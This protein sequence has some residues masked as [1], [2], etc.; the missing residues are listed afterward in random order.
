MAL[1]PCRECGK[2][3]SDQAESCPNCGIKTPSAKRRKIKLAIRALVVVVIVAVISVLGV[4]VYHFYQN[5]FGPPPAAVDS[6][7][8]AVPS[9]K[10]QKAAPI[11]QQII[12]KDYKEKVGELLDNGMKVGKISKET[13]LSRKEIK[14]VKREKEKQA[15]QKSEH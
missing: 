11:K 1:V 8:K 15:E 4:K 14:E 2:E 9:P 10:I 13:G 7:G 12:Q 6:N 3:V 5:T